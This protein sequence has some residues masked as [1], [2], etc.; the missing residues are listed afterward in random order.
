MISDGPDSGRSTP[1]EQREWHRRFYTQYT[2]APYMVR[3]TRRATPC[4]ARSSHEVQN[5]G[6]AR[7]DCCRRLARM[8]ATG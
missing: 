3:P 6:T 5:N 8:A 2:S 4:D 1:L 7:T